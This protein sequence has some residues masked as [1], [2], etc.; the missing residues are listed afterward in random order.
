[1]TEIEPMP[2]IVIPQGPRKSPAEIKEAYRR[3]KYRRTY[4]AG[5]FTLLNGF[6]LLIGVGVFTVFLL[7]HDRVPGL[8]ALVVGGLGVGAIG[9]G[10]QQ[11]ASAKRFSPRSTASVAGDDEDNP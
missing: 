11:L 7:Q 5:L 2:Q 1:M 6:S 8:W 10:M 9:S 3:N 4:Y